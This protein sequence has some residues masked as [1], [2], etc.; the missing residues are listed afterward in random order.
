MRQC[1]RMRGVR[2]HHP[3]L[4]LNNEELAITCG[5][6]GLY[7]PFPSLT[8]RRKWGISN[9]STDF[10]L[11]SRGAQMML[12]AQRFERALAWLR[13]A[14]G[15]LITAGAGMGVDSGLPDFR[16]RAGLWRAYPA[17]KQA[18]IAFQAIANP[19]AFH[20]L[21]ALAWG[22]YGHR[23]ELYRKTTP[24]R[25]YAIL[26]RWASDMTHGAF[27]FTSN[28]D[29]HF[30]KAGFPDDRI[31]ECHGTLHMLQCARVC[32]MDIWSADSLVPIVDEKACRLRSPLPACANCG[33][34]AR[35]NIL[36]F[37][38]WDWIS[39][40]ADRQIARLERWRAKVKSGVRWVGS[41]IRRQA[42]AEPV[43][44]RSPGFHP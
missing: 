1:P 32:T 19:K 5:E 44:C 24:H 9:K 36:M 8:Y 11:S 41:M 33:G 21:P 43:C 34:L 35:P 3:P 14:D 7:S 37:N 2:S 18:R 26:Q 20:H 13:D 4:R 28:V 25:G 39:E 42:V 16:G 38:D 23:L 15:L 27:V 12:E 29:G 6:S 40:R 31:V 10:S 22:F 30:A 17:L